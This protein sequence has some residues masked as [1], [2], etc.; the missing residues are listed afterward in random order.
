L[1][2][3]PE[4]RDRWRDRAFQA[5][6]ARLTGRSEESIAK[7]AQLPDREDEQEA[8]Q[9]V[10]DAA[11]R[12]RRAKQLY[13]GAAEWRHAGLREMLKEKYLVKGRLLARA[14]SLDRLVKI[15]SEEFPACGETTTDG[16]RVPATFKEWSEFETDLGQGLLE[17]GVPKT[18]IV[19]LLCRPNAD[20]EDERTRILQNLRRK[21][22]RG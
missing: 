13:E 19:A 7:M 14:A 20:P 15:L 1:A 21:P 2:E 6:Q 3:S 10:K 4:K 8:Y 16:E 18:R 5:R 22:R 11:A 17:V 9:L 12:L